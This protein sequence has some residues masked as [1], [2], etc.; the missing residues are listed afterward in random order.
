MTGQSVD[1]DAWS[2]SWVSTEGAK[3]R[4]NRH[5]LTVPSTLAPPLLP[6]TLSISA[7]QRIITAAS[8]RVG[9]TRAGIK[10]PHFVKMKKN[11]NDWPHQFEGFNIICA[12]CD[13]EVEQQFVTQRTATLTQSFM[14]SPNV[15]CCLCDTTW[16][17]ECLTSSTYNSE[18]RD[19]T[20]LKTER[21][22]GLNGRW[23][24]TEPHKLVIDDTLNVRPHTWLL[25]NKCKLLF[26]KLMK[27]CCI[28]F[29]P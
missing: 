16:H 10:M 6:H 17:L 4:S 28:M 1:A 13:C 9:T 2:L 24:T 18:V 27:S 29:S 3:I 25:Y 21:Q 20:Y 12:L 23:W 26:E 19:Y 11:L 5:G 14:D 8:T 15:D 7:S 22:E